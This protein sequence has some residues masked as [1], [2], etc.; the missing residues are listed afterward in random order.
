MK[1][2][3]TQLL[4]ALAAGALVSGA[5]VAQPAV[6]PSEAVPLPEVQHVSSDI[7]YVTGGVAY[8][9]LP[10][11]HQARPDYPLNVEV[12]EK[13]GEKNQF[14]A[15]AEVKLIGRGGNVVL[16]ATA[17]G[18]YLWAKVPP[19][20]YTLQTTLN[21]KMLERRVSVNAN[22]PTRAIVVFPQGTGDR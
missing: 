13:A 16:D 15:D 20:Q 8:E 11:F 7:S 12:Y 22:S 9:Q 17:D 19:G 18:P 4:C 2:N 10:S 21:G 3:P 1:F 6:S 5:A 14:T